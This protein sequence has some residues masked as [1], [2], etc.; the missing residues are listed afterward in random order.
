MPKLL[1]SQTNTKRGDRPINSGEALTD[2]EG[3]LVKLA[4]AGSKEEVVLPTSAKDICVF[5]VLE[6]EALDTDSTVRPLVSD[7]QVRAIAKGTGSA[8][9]VLVLADPA[10]S[11]DKGKVR[12]APAAAGQY[13]SPGLAEEDFEDGQLVKIRPLPHLIQVGQTHQ[14]IAAGV[15]AWAGGA[16][17]TDSISI[18][19]LAAN[20]V[21]VATLA[22][23]NSTE[24]LV[25]AVNDSANGQIDLTLSAN[26][27]NGNTKI[28]YQVLR[29]L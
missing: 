22:G 6:G 2:K 19:G 1:D 26:G 25:L 7:Q 11:A 24:Q 20:D 3:F 21:I 28:A 9:D 10:V 13:F 18:A 29:A 8:G 14:T 16:A 27:S 12:S 17:T 15:H 5:V 23:R 4:D